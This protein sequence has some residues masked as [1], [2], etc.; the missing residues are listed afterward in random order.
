[1][2]FELPAAL[3]LRVVH[4]PYV[5]GASVIMFGVF[6]VC[7]ASARS[8]APV[9]IL[10][11]LIGLAEAFVQTGFVFISLWYLPHELTTRCG[12]SSRCTSTPTGS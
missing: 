9:M 10:R 1:M 12:M 11:L 2:V 4:P 5:Y 7:M 6:A 3:S 8:Y